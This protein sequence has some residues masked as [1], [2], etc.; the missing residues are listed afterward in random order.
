MTPDPMHIQAM[1][2]LTEAMRAAGL[3]SRQ[4]RYHRS[5]HATASPAEKSI[6]FRYESLIKKRS[7]SGEEDYGE[8]R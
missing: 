7:G 3:C 8:E 4:V 1:S 2:Q 6:C 5:E